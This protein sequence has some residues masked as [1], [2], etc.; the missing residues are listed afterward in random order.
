MPT[1]PL[2]A[3][4][5]EIAALLDPI[6]HVDDVEARVLAL[7]DA[8]LGRPYLAFTLVGGP[9]E[10]EQMV[11]RL[12]GFDCVTFVESVWALAWSRHPD[13]YERHLRALRYK[14]GQVAWLNRNHFMNLWI[15]RNVLAERAE[16]LLRDAYVQTGELR[17]LSALPHYPVQAW[18][19]GYVPSSALDV[20]AAHA[21]PGDLV[22]FVSNKPNLDTF[23]VGLLVPDEE[24][25]VAVRHAGRSAGHVL[26]QQLADFLTTNDVPGMLLARPASRSPSLFLSQSQAETPLKPITVVLTAADAPDV[27]VR[28][29]AASGLVY[30]AILIAPPGHAT[31]QTELA[32]VPCVE[33]VSAE[34]D[35]GDT[36]RKVLE[37][38]DTPLLLRATGDVDPHPTALRRM[39]AALNDTG[40]AM[41]FGDYMD[42]QDDGSARA[43]PLSDYQAGSLQDAFP[44]GPLQ[45]WSKARIEQAL[46][47]H[48]PISGLRFHAWYDVR[49]KANLV[50]A[51]LRLPEPLAVLRP[52]DQRRSGEQVFDYLTAS[53]E[54][55]IE[56]EQ[57]VTAYLERIGAKVSGPF[58]P[59]DA[60]GDFPVEISVVIPVR[61]RTR[62]IADAVRSAL[63]QQIEAS[64]ST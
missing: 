16:P 22:G 1:P 58:K 60:V 38:V 8:L 21:R 17:S 15:A 37:T 62:T 30:R 34:P 26:H 36:V 7:T 41:V 9:D 3:Q 45:L 56:A 44:F 19:V 52:M 32:G 14:D 31:G 39:A 18:N 33:I 35:S 50:G 2:R 48:G 20:L 12:D 43:H 59:Y 64:L 25:G 24:G 10:P 40:A 42:L 28:R 5:A 23:H 27:T 61:N 11:S 57:V 54:A 51:I 13:D 46:D 63:E 6:D 47:A 29:L 4:R 55:Q 49:L 53:R